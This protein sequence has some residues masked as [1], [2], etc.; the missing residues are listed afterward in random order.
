MLAPAL[1]PPADAFFVDC[2][3]A[4]GSAIVPARPR[5]AVSF[6]VAGNAHGVIRL[7]RLVAPFAPPRREGPKAGYGSLR[8]T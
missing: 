3:F 7:S 6:H 2:F 5:A 4:F 8:P 1:P